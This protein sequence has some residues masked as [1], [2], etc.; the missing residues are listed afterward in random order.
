MI[1]YYLRPTIKQENPLNSF[2]KII[3][4]LISF[5]GDIEVNK[6][7]ETSAII[8]YLGTPTT[9]HITLE[10]TG[11]LTVNISKDDNVTINLINNIA[12]NIGVRIYNPQIN[13][14]LPNDVN[15]LDLTTIKPDLNIKNVLNLYQ[16]TPLFQYRGALIFFCLNTKMEVVLINR[17]FLE[18]LLTAY[19]LKPKASELSVVVSPDIAT[20]VALFDRGL[21][22]LNFQENLKF[23]RNII[24]LSGF[25][26]QKLPKNTKLNIINFM[27][28][29]ENQSFVQ[30]DTAD[31]IPKKY[32][33]LKIGQDYTYSMVG[34]KLTK[35]LNC[36]VF[37]SSD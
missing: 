6:E 37:L 4:Y 3:D 15:I 31:K 23:D 21:I 1:Q 12:K 22:K 5:T 16:L 7:S 14:Y 20:F 24:N 18:F 36:S 32:L 28:D 2:N 19:N 29:E 34:T 10:K 33:A 25:N 17:H 30:T 8:Y 11:Q 35:I 26:L 27:F 13:C 9:A